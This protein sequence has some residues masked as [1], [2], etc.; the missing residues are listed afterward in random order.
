MP[1]EP[2]VVITRKDKRLKKGWHLLAFMLTGGASAPVSAAKGAGNA[3]YNARTRELQRRAEASR[4]T[5][6]T[7]KAADDPRFSDADHERA[8]R[9]G[10]AAQRRLSGE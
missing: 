2:Q 9:A 6:S 1:D 7:G 8:R 4:K 5:Y 10:K 3:A